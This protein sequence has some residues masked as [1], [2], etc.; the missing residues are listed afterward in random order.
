MSAGSQFSDSDDTDQQRY[1]LLHIKGSHEGVSP[2]KVPIMVEN[3]KLEMEVDTGAAVSILSST[4][5]N[6]HFLHIEMKSSPILLQTY[7]G[8]E[9]KVLGEIEVC[10]VIVCHGVSGEENSI[11]CC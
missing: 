8:E 3:Q 5:Y 10:H 11:G 7:T 4:D 2:F 9:V 6:K 1:P